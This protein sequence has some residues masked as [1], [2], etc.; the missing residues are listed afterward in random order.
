[1][2]AEG[3]AGV[4]SGVDPDHV[5]RQVRFVDR[6]RV[7]VVSTAIPAPD[8]GEVRVASTVSA[9]SPGTELLVYRDQ[10]PDDVALDETI[11]AL[12]GVASYPLSYGY[13]T[14]GRVTAA[15]EDVPDDWV[16]RR[17]FAFHPHAS[18]FCVDP[19]SLVPLPPAVD[20]DDAALLATVETAVSLVMDARP[21]IG[22]RVAVF[23]QG[24]VG[25]LTT[26]LLARFPLSR[27]VT[28][29]CYAARRERSRSLGAD[30]SLPPDAAAAPDPFEAGDGRADLSVEVSGNP[31]ALDAAIDATGDDGRVVVGSWYG[32]KPTALDLGGRFHRSHIRLQSSQVSRVDAA[33]AGRWDKARRMDL[34]RDRLPDLSP[35]D[36]VT[37]RL[38]VA[39]APEAYRLLDESPEDALQ[40]L[41][42]Y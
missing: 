24:V 21:R 3:G 31:A 9:I 4:D 27:L 15:G 1:M 32:T 17:V 10:V 33:H 28:Y 38:P 11:D 34:V 29:D 41:L 42:E 14:V 13:A 25:L 22:E 19:A 35:S 36:L 2:T 8:A 23:G 39:E 37:H 5:G 12:D 18:H 26:A 20:D 7:E 6:R 40:V 16:G 30:E